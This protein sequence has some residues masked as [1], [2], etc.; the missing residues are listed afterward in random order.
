MCKELDR[1]PPTPDL[2]GVLSFSRAL[3]RNNTREWFTAHRAEFDVASETFERVVGTLIAAISRFDPLGPLEPKDCIFRVYRDIRF[4]TDK[5]PY[6]PHFSAYMAP[7]GRKATR[8]GY[9]LHLQA[10]GSFLGGGFHMPEPRQLAA[11]RDAIAEDAKPFRRITGAKPFRAMF[12]EIEGER[13]KTAPR[14]FP[15]DHPELGLLRLK[16]VIAS[17]PF[18]DVMV[19]GPGF[20]QEVLATC[21]ALR[22]F[23]EYLGALT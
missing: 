20:Q 2:Q 14:G 15:K 21:K 22:P 1:M 5:T 19:T 10:G 12:G 16:S 8:L 17:R 11:F 23:L 4:S 9:Y 18:P 13:L 6:K 7:G 3:S